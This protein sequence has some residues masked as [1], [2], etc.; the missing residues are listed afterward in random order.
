MTKNRMDTLA[1][2]DERRL[3]GEWMQS[4]F[5]T[6]YREDLPLHRRWNQKRLRDLIDGFAIRGTHV[7]CQATHG[8]PLRVLPNRPTHAATPTHAMAKNALR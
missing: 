6:V 2:S 3:V 8:L 4:S 1:K 7:V 5:S